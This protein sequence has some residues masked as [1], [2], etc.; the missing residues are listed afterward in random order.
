MDKIAAI[1]NEI[2][3]LEQLFQL[4]ETESGFTSMKFSSVKELSDGIKSNTIS[5]DDLSILIVSGSSK[6]VDQ[7]LFQKN[8]VLLQ[9]LQRDSRLKKI[10]LLFLGYKGDSS[11]QDICETLG[12]VYLGIPVTKS[13]LISCVRD[14]LTQKAD[15]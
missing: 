9:Q 11:L 4:I 2:P 13:R 12:A 5:I 3:K 15:F 1:F 10:P 7:T 8:I 14:L 6:D